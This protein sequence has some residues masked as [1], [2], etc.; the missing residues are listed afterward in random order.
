MKNRKLANLLAVLMLLPWC[1][2]C[3]WPIQ[4]A[5]GS[6]LYEE[7]QLALQRI[8]KGTDIFSEVAFQLYCTDCPTHPYSKEVAL[9]LQSVA[10]QL[11]K[12]EQAAFAVLKAAY[13]PATRT[14]ALSAINRASLESALN[15][16]R[17]LLPT[18]TDSAIPSDAALKLQSLLQVVLS[19]VDKL[20]AVLGRVKS[21]AGDST[22][23]VILSERQGRELEA[24]IR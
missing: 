10:L 21:A 19:S 2:G 12:Y 18:G 1:G 8:D 24:A 3:P 4:L 11:N 5:R 23:Q 17:A 13:D 22:F 6:N 16:I 20:L 7:S 9:Q 14:F 15:A